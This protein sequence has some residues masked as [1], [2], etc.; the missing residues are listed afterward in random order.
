[1]SSR[2]SAT[3]LIQAMKELSREWEQTKSYW[4]DVKSQEF[5]AN[6][7]SDLPQDIGGAASAM[8]EIENVLQKIRKDC[9]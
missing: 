3:N 7:L 1:M 9:E 8:E 4:R 5:E 6:Y 2:A